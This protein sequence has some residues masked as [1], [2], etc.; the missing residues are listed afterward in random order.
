MDTRQYLE[1]ALEIY[2]RYLRQ[3]NV[4]MGASI[5]RTK[6]KLAQ[7][8]IEH[9]KDGARVIDLEYDVIQYMRGIGRTEETFT[10]NDFDKLVFY[11]S[12]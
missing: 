7:V 4:E 9:D 11:W 1:Q 12:K 5:A 2:T 10:E 6:W 8:L 3:K